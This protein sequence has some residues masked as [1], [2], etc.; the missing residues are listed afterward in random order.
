[1]TNKPLHFWA[2]RFEISS[3]PTYFYLSELNTYYSVFFD[4]SIIFLNAFYTN[5]KKIYKKESDTTV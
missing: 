1:M 2:L 4:N 5:R 3:Y